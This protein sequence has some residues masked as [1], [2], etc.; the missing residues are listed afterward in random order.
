M[1]DIKEKDINAIDENLT[2]L[3]RYKL[4]RRYR[5]L[6]QESK[7]NAVDNKQ[8]ELRYERE[9][10]HRQQ[11]L[12]RLTDKEKEVTKQLSVEKRQARLNRLLHLKVSGQRMNLLAKLFTA[13]SAITSMLGLGTACT[14]LDIQ[15]LIISWT[16][17]KNLQYFFVG[18]LFFIGELFCG[19]L[20]GQTDTINEFFKT[21]QL[22]NKCMSKGIIIYSSLVYVTSIYSNGV[23]WWN[24]TESLLVT[25]I[26]SFLFDIGG[27]VCCYYGYKYSNLDSEKIQSDTQN[28]HDNTRVK[29]GENTRIH[30]SSQ[31]VENRAIDTITRTSKNASKKPSV[32]RTS[33]SKITR[34]E[35]E[36]M[37][38]QNFKDGQVIKPGMVGMTGN[39]NFRNW[40]QKIN[41][42]TKNENGEWIKQTPK[43][44][45]V[46]N[47]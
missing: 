8:D 1:F 40:M 21:D 47:D 10:L 38:D 39:S 16:E 32:R 37:I 2:T 27:L 19:W 4:N 33:N 17:F 23:F 25:I 18:I 7:N 35:L 31:T 3:D 24:L 42:V 15:E 6:A 44:T 41:A 11:K 36:Q 30:E 9:K 20:F 46:K 22:I 12:D 34:A 28:I 45:V 43:F 26:Y 14:N 13:I 29:N 5:Q